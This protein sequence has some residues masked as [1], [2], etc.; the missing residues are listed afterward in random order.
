MKPRFHR[1]NNGGENTIEINKV[2]NKDCV[3]FMKAI[4]D[5]YIDLIIADPPYYKIVKEEWD[6][7]WSNEEEYY[8]FCNEWIKESFRILKE[9]GALY[10]WNWFDNICELGHLAKNNG[11]IIRN[12]IT[13]N[14][15]AGREKNNYCSA[16]EDLLY[17]TKNK[18]PIFNLN[19]ILLGLDD[20]NRKM[21]KSSWQRLQYEM[22]GRKS[23]ENNRVN[24]SNVWFDNFIML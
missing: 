3:E 17:L 12:L 9:N 19:D 11:F 7:Q 20:P 22:K 5:K 23:F 15:G 18:N 13:W 10:I 21:K 24:P 4:P 14:R 16:K 6:N 8:E 2:H 1:G